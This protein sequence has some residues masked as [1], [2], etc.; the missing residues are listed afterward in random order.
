MLIKTELPSY[1]QT[2]VPILFMYSLPSFLIE[3]N[4]AYVCVGVRARARAHLLYL[5]FYFNFWTH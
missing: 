3:R 4:Q 5:R 1:A 2:I